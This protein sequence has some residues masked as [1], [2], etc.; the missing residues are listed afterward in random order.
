MDQLKENR[1]LVAII[2]GVVLTLLIYLVAVMPA[3]D[4]ATKDGK[5]NTQADLDGLRGEV[6]K[7]PKKPAIETKRRERILALKEVYNCY[8]VYSRLAH[9]LRAYLVPG[10]EAESTASEFQAKLNAHIANLLAHYE[11]Y[12]L[13]PTVATEKTVSSS[14][15]SADRGPFADFLTNAQRLE[16]KTEVRYAQKQFW[17]LVE[18]VNALKEAVDEMTK[19]DRRATPPICVLKSVVFPRGKGGEPRSATLGGVDVSNLYQGIAF[20]LEMQCD[21]DLWPKFRAALHMPKPVDVQWKPTDSADAVMQRIGLRFDRISCEAKLSPVLDRIAVSLKED[22]EAQDIFNAKW[23]GRYK[24]EQVYP[25]DPNKAAQFLDEVRAELLAKLAATRAPNTVYM[26]VKITGEALDFLPDESK[27]NFWKALNMSEEEIFQV[28][29]NGTNA[30]TEKLA[31]SRWPKCAKSGKPTANNKTYLPEDP[32]TAAILH[33][34]VLHENAKKIFEEK[35][36]AGKTE[37]DNSSTN[38]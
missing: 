24:D 11:K 4:S 32:F 14:D 33:D 16:N 17:V 19:K 13:P 15:G 12:K 26:N 28:L 23:P 8:L 25:P 38:Q 6:D 30:Q 5:K 36:G 3:I 1:I 18:L 35:V 22:Q 10:T 37:G 29:H 2:S 21:V 27:I 7:A 9:P 34:E 31:E 20:E